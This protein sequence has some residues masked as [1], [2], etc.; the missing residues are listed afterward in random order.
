MAAPLPA[1]GVESIARARLAEVRDVGGGR[2]RAD[3]G[4]TAGRD[5]GAFSAARLGAAFVGF[6]AAA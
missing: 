1:A 5:V 2:L 6:G 3:A 4:R